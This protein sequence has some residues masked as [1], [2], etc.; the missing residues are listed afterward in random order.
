MTEYIIYSDLHIGSPYAINLEIEPSKNAVL[1]GDNFELKNVLAKEIDRI[2]NL[3]ENT[4]K[5]IQEIGGIFLDGNHELEIFDENN[6]FIRREE[7]LFIHGDIIEWGLSGA[8]RRRSRKISINDYYWNF[9]KI[10]RK[11]ILDESYPRK[12]HFENPAKNLA[13]SSLENPNVI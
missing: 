9:M 2:K 10:F 13:A 12:K 1:L 5:R 6:F 3:R 7:V 8:N 4:M 11:F